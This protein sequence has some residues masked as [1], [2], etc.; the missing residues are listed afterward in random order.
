MRQTPGE[1]RLLRDI[2]T[3]RRRRLFGSVAVLEDCVVFEREGKGTQRIASVG[4]FVLE[5]ESGPPRSL[6][7][8]ADDGKRFSEGNTRYSFALTFVFLAVAIACILLGHSSA[9][10]AALVFALISL[11]LTLF[12]GSRTRMVNY[13]EHIQTPATLD[14]TPSGNSAADSLIDIGREHLRELNLLALQVRGDSLKSN[15]DS[16]CEATRQLLELLSENPGKTKQAKQLIDYALPTTI[17]LLKQYAD[18]DR[19]PVKG[20]NI[21]KSMDKI[22]EMSGSVAEIM[23]RELD[24]LYADRTFDIEVDVEVLQNMMRQDMNISDELKMDE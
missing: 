20:E 17:K 24:A 16:I 12:L 3:V 7:I 15:V 9:V 5:R 1:K 19:Q 14:F 18:L 23:R 6:M 11:V 21:R 10:I 2:T 13:S 22:V 8:I 4:P